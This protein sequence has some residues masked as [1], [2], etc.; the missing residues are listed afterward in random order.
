M[1]RVIAEA[2]G[3]INPMTVKPGTLLVIPKAQGVMG[4]A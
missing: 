1:W 3:V 4:R 2:N